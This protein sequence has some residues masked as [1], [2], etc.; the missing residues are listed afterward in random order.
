M[1]GKEG[2]TTWGSQPF[3]FGLFE[4]VKR[5]QGENPAAIFAAVDATAPKP[6]SNPQ[7]SRRG[8][9]RPIIAADRHRS[10][11]GTSNLFFLRSSCT[12]VCCPHAHI[13]R[14]DH[15]ALTRRVI[16]LLVG[17]GLRCADS[18]RRRETEH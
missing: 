16:G 6:G 10:T 14:R 8:D 7:S 13:A 4:R 9:L 2:L 3:R 11:F 12:V 15:E 1:S 17:C 18:K 5:S